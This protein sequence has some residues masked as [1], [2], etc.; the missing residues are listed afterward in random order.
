[1]LKKNSKIF[2]AGHNGLVGAAV[3]K[4]LK[5]RQYKNI[6]TIS[7]KKLDLTNQSKVN[8]FFKKNKIDYVVLAAA[9]VGGILSNSVY[10][11]DFI[12]QNLMIQ[13]NVINAAH[14]N[15]I[16][17][18]IFLGSSCVYPN[19]INRPI[20]EKDLLSSYLEKTNE[21][22]AIAKIAGIKMCESFNNQYGLNY[23]CLMPC[24][25]FGEND[26]F[27]LKNSHFL[28]AI[29]H[30]VY[31]YR[32][33][34]IKKLELFG[35]GKPYRELMYVDDLA[36]AIIFFMKK[37]TKETLINIGSGYEK[38]IDYYVK[39][40]CKILKANDIEIKYNND[41]KM[42]GTNRKIL[43]CTIAKSYGW[44]AKSSFDASLKK[45]YDYFLRNVV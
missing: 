34:K 18:L 30:K 22:Y 12:Y 29:M 3:V 11:A 5:K 38:T 26:N 39:K 36:E 44:K 1:M 2:V 17:N 6:L 10:K 23:K 7:K 31:L 4:L 32:K 13:S 42:N 20:K 15:G 21:P 35:N 45:T 27:D 14:I 25:I 41:L 33:K 28:P 16:K 24:N 19:N 9:K 8:N 40:I 43:N 37:K